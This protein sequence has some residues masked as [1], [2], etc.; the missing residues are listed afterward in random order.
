MGSVVSVCEDCRADVDCNGTIDA[1]DLGLI[2]AAWNTSE[3][4][5]DLDGD[6][7]VAGGDLGLLLGTWGVCK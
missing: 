4:Q 1:A 3:M 2:L 5:Y 6:G 7:V